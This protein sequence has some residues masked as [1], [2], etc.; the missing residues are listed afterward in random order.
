M[1]T[2][3]SVEVSIVV[4][5]QYITL[6]LFGKTLENYFIKGLISHLSPSILQR[7]CNFSVLKQVLSICTNFHND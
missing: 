1:Q 5:S 3:G 4:W 7:F 6:K 2:A